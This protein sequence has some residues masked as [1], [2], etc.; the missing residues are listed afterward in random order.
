M[1]LL[2]QLKEERFTKISFYN[3]HNEWEFSDLVA[4]TSNDQL[5]KF[6]RI[7]PVKLEY[8]PFEIKPHIIC[9][10]ENHSRKFFL[11]R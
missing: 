2:Q 4:F 5:L 10:D 3:E 1:E 11:F 6:M 8:Y 9:Y 7:N